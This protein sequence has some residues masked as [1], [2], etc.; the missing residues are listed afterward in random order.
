[1]V[2][3]LLLRS[4]IAAVLL[5]CAADAAACDL[6]A[7]ASVLTDANNAECFATSGFRFPPDSAPTPQSFADT[8]ATPACGALIK[9]VEKLAGGECTL[10]ALKVMGD[11]VTPFKRACGG[12]GDSSSTDKPSS[13]SSDGGPLVNGNKRKTNKDG[14]SNDSN[15]KSTRFKGDGSDELSVDTNKGDDPSK[16][17]T[18]R[19]PGRNGNGDVPTATPKSNQ[20]VHAL[21]SAAPSVGGKPSWLPVVA[22][23]V[24]A[25]VAHTAL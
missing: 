18:P 17:L 1:M 20:V 8:C 12:G 15:G 11:I 6:N 19:T 23:T 4:S 21:H 7:L 16:P 3:S 22:A 10:G 5:V 2:A 13:G 24:A 14:S 9:R 25:I